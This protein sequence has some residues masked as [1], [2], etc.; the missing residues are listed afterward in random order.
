MPRAAA[1]ETHRILARSILQHLVEEGAQVGS[2]V[3]ELGLSQTM[4]VS[5]SPVRGALQLLEGEGIIVRGD[6][7]RFSLMRLPQIEDMASGPLDES[8]EVEALYWKIASDRLTNIIEA[9]TAEADLM[10]RYD[11]S[12]SLIQRT[13]RQI[14]SE[15]W[16]EPM[17]TGAWR[18]L[19]LIDG[20]ESYDESYRFRRAIEPAALLDPGFELTTVTANRLRREQK[21]LLEN[22][23][24]TD[25]RQVF[26]HN[27][28]FHLAL[29]QAS[30]NRFFADAALRITRLRRVVGYVI[31]LDHTR[32]P[33]QSIE[34]LAILD[35]IEDGD[36][37]A[38][39]R[40]M[41]RHLKVGQKSKAELLGDHRLTITGPSNN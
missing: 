12:R 41:A 29:M 7:R 39:A 8:G 25:P 2:P 23:D 5:R 20:R 37:Q 14:A 28:G 15:G 19:P 21:Y 11:A 4:G 30:N 16:A 27:S 17:P 22:G 9:T 40:L 24:S 1:S 38:A 35:R 36:L 3:S 26:E 6:N 18:F 34:H 32:T 13:L 10:R 31:A 33:T